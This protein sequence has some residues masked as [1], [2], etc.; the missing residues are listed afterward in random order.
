MM[1][2]VP[3]RTCSF[4]L[5]HAYNNHAFLV[6]E[7]DILEWDACCAAIASAMMQ[8]ESEQSKHLLANITARWQRLLGVPHP[9]HYLSTEFCDNV[10]D[11]HE[12]CVCAMDGAFLFS[13]VNRTFIP[14]ESMARTQVIRALAH[15]FQSPRFAEDQFL[16]LPTVRNYVACFG[17]TDINTTEE[18]CACVG[19]GKVDTRLGIRLSCGH[20]LHV[21]CSLGIQDP[22]CRTIGHESSFT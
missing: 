8:S 13:A 3:S 5:S 20:K 18:A 16:G 2:C 14:L 22:P 1:L 12:A 10:C 17:V 6:M 4:F 15:H 9:P 19:C 21:S 7:A 11:V